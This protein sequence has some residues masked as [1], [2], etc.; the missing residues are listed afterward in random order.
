MMYLCYE[1]MNGEACKVGFKSESVDCKFLKQVSYL[2]QKNTAER[3]MPFLI[4]YIRKKDLLPGNELPP[5]NKLGQIIGVGHQALRET[6]LILLSIGQIIANLGKDW[7]VGKFD[8]VINL[9]CIAPI[10][11]GF[12]H[13]D[14]EGISVSIKMKKNILRRKI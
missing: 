9:R 12:C 7:Y 1:M 2:Q 6:L 13:S 5:M 8:S 10:L 14:W 4:Q 3:I 11:Q